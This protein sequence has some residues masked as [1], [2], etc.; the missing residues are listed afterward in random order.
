MPVINFVR[1]GS[2]LNISV[3]LFTM[4]NNSFAMELEQSVNLPKNRSKPLLYSTRRFYANI[5]IKVLQHH[6]TYR[7]SAISGIGLTRREI[8]SLPAAMDWAFDELDFTGP[9]KVKYKDILTS[10]PMLQACFMNTPL[11]TRPHRSTWSLNSLQVKHVL[12]LNAAV[13]K[14]GSITHATCLVVYLLFVYGLRLV[15]L[16]NM[17]LEDVIC[18]NSGISVT[19]WSYKSRVSL[20]HRSLLSMD[21]PRSD[22]VGFSWMF[23]MIAYARQHHHSGRIFHACSS[24]QDDYALGLSDQK[25]LYQYFYNYLKWIF[26]QLGVN[27]EGGTHCGRRSL[28][29]NCSDSLVGRIAQQLGISEKTARERYRKPSLASAS[30][31]HG[32]LHGS[33]A[34]YGMSSM[35]IP[36]AE[37]IGDGVSTWSLT[38][39]VLNALPLL[40]PA[41][42]P[43][44]QSG[45]NRVNI[46]P[47]ENGIVF[48]SSDSDETRLEK[49]LK[50]GYYK[51]AEIVGSGVFI[52]GSARRTFIR[53]RWFGYG[54]NDDTWE[55]I[56]SLGEPHRHLAFISWRDKGFPQVTHLVDPASVPVDR[57]GRPLKLLAG[58]DGFC[59][60]CSLECHSSNICRICCQSPESYSILE[61]TGLKKRNRNNTYL[62]TRKRNRS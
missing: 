21:I 25:R 52:N 1:K 22:S 42:D 37:D 53:C 41:T 39:E 54:P 32:L 62:G 6:P 34:S 24:Y 58:L 35:K 12:E 26:K 47:A 45:F 61:P 30:E 31:L 23:N 38:P 48:E 28:F 2:R 19:F 60:S 49:E 16:L 51:V 10:K 43:S 56:G 8:H 18:S 17:M 11:Q 9:E 57:S 59:L 13:Y 55:P 14:K 5:A 29:T 15:D 4:T 40:A 44:P 33:S 50:Y 46:S 27:P 20:R 3:D 36:E 7:V